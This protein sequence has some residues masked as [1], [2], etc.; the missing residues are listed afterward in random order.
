QPLLTMAGQ[1]QLAIHGMAAGT[2]AGDLQPGQAGSIGGELAVNDLS[3]QTPQLAD[4][5]RAATVRVPVK[6]ARA[7]SGGVSRLQADL[8]VIA[9][10]ATLKIDGDLPESALD[11]L[12]DKKIPAQPGTIALSLVADPTKLAHSLPKTMHLQPGM[13]IDS[14]AISGVVSLAIDPA[15]NAIL[16]HVKTGLSVSGTQNGQA[17]SIPPVNLVADAALTRLDGVVAG[18][19]DVSL[20]LSSGF[21]N[22]KL[23]GPTVY[24]LQGSGDAD[25]DKLASQASQF[26][27]LGQTRLSGQANF[28]LAT[29]AK[30]GDV[31]HAEV[32][33][34]VSQLNATLPQKLPITMPIAQLAAQ[35]DVQTDS[36]TS[37]LKS[38][39]SA[40]LSLL[41]GDSATKPLVEF[42]S[43]IDGYDVAA[44]TIESMNVDKCTVSSLHD[45]QTRLIDPFV[46]RLMDQGLNLADGALYLVARVAQVNVNTKAADIQQLDVSLPSLKIDRQGQELLR[47]TLRASIVGKAAA[48]DQATS[49]AISKLSFE[50]GF[51]KVNGSDIQAQLPDGKTPVT[52]L[53]KK[54]K[55]AVGVSDLTK[56]QALLST[57]SPTTKLPAHFG[58]GVA[59]NISVEKGV[60]S[61]DLAGSHLSAAND[62]GMAFAF[63]KAKPTTVKAAFDIPPAMPIT[64]L[65]VSQLDADLDVA[66]VKLNGPLV[67]TNLGAQP[68]AKGQLA[69]GGSLDRLTALLQVI[70]SSNT[71][72]PYRGTLALNEAIAT[73]NNVITLKGDGTIDQFRM[74][75]ADGKSQFAEPKLALANDLSVDPAKQMAALKSVHLEMTSSK[76]ATVDLSG[77]VSQWSTQRNLDSIVFKLN[78][79]GAKAWPLVVAMMSPEQQEKYKDTVVK[80]PVTADFAVSGAYP[81][82]P[83][84]NESFRSIAGKG[85]LTADFV[86]SMGLNISKFA[87][88][89]TIQ[90][91]QVITGD[92]S[93]PKGAGRQVKPF[94]VNGGKADFSNIVLNAGDPNLLL[95][96]GKGQKLLQQVQLNSVLA[97]QLGSL[98]SVVFKDS[99]DA[100]G[101][102]DLTVV[103]CENVRLAE[104]MNKQANATFVYSIT[105]L[106]LDG[107]VP[108]T[109]ATL[110]DLGDQG[111]VGNIKD[112]SLALKQGVAYQDMTIGVQKMM[113]QT[114]PQTGAKTKVATDQPIQ[115]K[116]GVDLATN[117]FKDYSMTIANQLL[118]RDWRKSFPDGATVKLT[119]N[120]NDISSI[121]GQSVGTLA[122]QGYGGGQIDKLLGG[123]GNA[124]KKK[125]KSE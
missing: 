6:I 117:K 122:V 93:A 41:A 33:A 57:I 1:P 73:E 108:S 25:L 90:K 70:Q 30:A 31:I 63:N 101:L 9:P 40:T 34:D 7:M 55:L 47:D 113:D 74:I 95:S 68:Q 69:I 17:K 59:V 97:A 10:E 99:K 39:Q 78:A 54:A 2:I 48:V 8:S 37:G 22:L 45:A 114:D 72:L 13:S 5:Y 84:W 112:A 111:F 102:I 38:V 110:L 62:S 20:A 58:G 26:V 79:D 23:A 85:T 116:G 115:F 28:K 12:K 125:K 83:T 46:S 14:G 121:L 49:L 120:V 35:A 64:S 29:Q 75:G 88:P 19:H 82:A 104:L 96:I 53:L 89:L 16:S 124:K 119:G 4:V 43:T 109:L 44:G 80:G 61:V 60:G 123:L 51:A 66:Q 27:D 42:K 105:N 103:Q 36:A 32:S 91:G 76:A 92:M 24:T 67:L 100:S 106:K 11:A 52:Q 77:G 56:A 118:L 65:N 94:D 107:P 87:L 50:S 81:V 71:Q 15:K 98:A 18:L 86:S 21:A 3:V